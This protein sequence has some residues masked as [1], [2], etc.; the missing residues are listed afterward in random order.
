M[1]NPYFVRLLALIE[2]A[3]QLK[4]WEGLLSKDGKSLC[5]RTLVERCNFPRS[6]LYQNKAV[7]Q[8]IANTDLYL[9][10]IGMRAE[11]IY[12]PVDQSRMEEVIESM[13]QRIDAMYQSISKFNVNLHL[14]LEAM[15]SIT[16]GE[17]IR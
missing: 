5:R 2:E 7:A 9:R 17:M 11:T 4:T 8:L 12:A 1:S 16:N 3:K 13:E 14:H 10:N 6:T 15:N